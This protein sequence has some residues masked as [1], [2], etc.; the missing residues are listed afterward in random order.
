MPSPLI[1]K[2]DYPMLSG[3]A[4]V[5]RGTVRTISFLSDGTPV[6]EV[7]DAAAATL[8]RAVMGAHVGAA[9][10]GWVAGEVF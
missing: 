4:W 1:Q 5:R 10:T 7:Y 6:S 8:E 3:G 2:H 9:E